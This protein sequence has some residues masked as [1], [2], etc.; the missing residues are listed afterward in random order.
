MTT[1]ASRNIKHWWVTASDIEPAHAWHW[2]SFFEDYNDPKNCFDW[3]GPSWIRSRVSFARIKNMHKD[4]IVVAYQARKGIVGLVYLASNGYQSP[5][6]TNFNSFDLRP[7]PNVRLNRLVPYEVVRDAKNAASGIEFVGA[8][9]KQGS[10]FGI[11]PDG[12]DT[13]ISLMV[14]FNPE[15]E[16]EIAAFLD[17]SAMPAEARVEAIDSFDEL[18]PL[19]RKLLLTQRIIRDSII[20][21]RL[22]ELYRYE[23]QICGETIELPDGKRYAEVHHLRPVGAPHNG[24]D[25]ASNILVVCPKHHAMLDFGAIA[26]NPRSL[27]VEHWKSGKLAKLKVL[28]HE[29]NPSSLNYHYSRLFKGETKSRG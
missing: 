12:F 15:Q 3:G 27:T 9:V 5:K 2:D 16:S 1:R 14:Q 20:G 17:V 21:K 4:D 26:I 25:G 19:Q 8:K 13:L 24:K 22:K 23:C 18:K 29:L 6:G 11:E 10:V 28:K 7:S